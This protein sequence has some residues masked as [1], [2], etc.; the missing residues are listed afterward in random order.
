METFTSNGTET[1]IMQKDVKEKHIK[2]EQWS[3]KLDYML[4]ILGYLVGFGNIWRFPYICMKNGGGAFLI[5]YVIA[6]F[7]MVIPV[8]FLEVSLGQ[9]TGKSFK[10]VWSYCPLLKGLGVGLQVMLVLGISYYIMLLAWVMY[11]VYFSFLN[12]LPWSTCDNE[13]NTPY[14]FSFTENKQITTNQSTMYSTNVT[15][16]NLYSYTTDYHGN[17]TDASSISYP[18]MSNINGS[19]TN[20]TLQGVKGHSAEEEFWQY[21]VLDRSEGVD[22]LGSLKSHLVLCMVVA[23]IVVYLCVIKGIKS[24]GKVVYVTATLPYILLT[25]LLVHNLTLPGSLDGIIF[26][27]KPDFQSLLN[28]QVWLEA[29]IQVFYSI[30]IGWGI[31]I[32]L[33]SF[34]KFNNNCLRDTFIMTLAGEGTSVFGGFVIFS[35]LG[36]MAHEAN[37]PIT[38]VSKSGPGLGFVAYPMAIAQMPLPNLWAILFFVAMVTLGLDSQFTLTEITYVYFEECFAVIKRK[39]MI[40]RACLTLIAMVLGL[41]FCTQAGVYL[42]QFIDW[43]L[44]TLG[45]FIFTL[46]ECLSVAWLYGSERFSNDVEMMIGKRVPG[47]IKFCWSFLSP[48]LLCVL[49]IASLALYVPPTY[50]DYVYPS[51]IG[52][53]GWVLACVPIVPIVIIGIHVIYDSPGKTIYQKLLQ[54][55]RPTLDWHPAVDKDE[56]LSLP[57]ETQGNITQKVLFNVGFTKQQNTP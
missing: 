32:T 12:P 6:L 33:A 57:W 50:G 38:E 39:R 10:D 3:R 54:T 5:P 56:Y 23:W 18:L 27:I 48:L 17:V 45:P 41:P 13:W 34:N 4:T 21:K 30:T 2:K 16:H 44:A 28:I 43:Y 26:F 31:H 9:F 49:I 25:T 15:G 29:T 35:A 24:T 22:H 14:C 36:F 53:A 37:V 19:L 51:W 47:Y 11:Y 52:N 55:V 20:I 8:Y 46:A 40:G 7:L 42:F 1:L